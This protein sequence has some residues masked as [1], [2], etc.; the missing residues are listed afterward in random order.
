[1][2]AQEGTEWED[3]AASSAV[4]QAAGPQAPVSD[5]AQT[6]YA[7]ARRVLQCSH[8]ISSTLKRA[9]CAVRQVAAPS[10]SDLKED[11]LRQCAVCDRGECE[12]DALAE[13]KG[14][15]EFC[16]S[17]TLDRVWCDEGRARQD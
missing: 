5:A 16:I 7:A 12:V 2:V 9:S 8:G 15:R 10:M 13:M 11:L 17:L 4:P 14:V 6:C 3:E 1:M